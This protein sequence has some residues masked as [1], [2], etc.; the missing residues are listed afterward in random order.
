MIAEQLEHSL[1]ESWY[2]EGN[3][4]AGHIRALDIRR[5]RLQTRAQSFKR[6]TCFALVARNYDGRRQLGERLLSSR[7]NDKRR[8]DCPKQSDDTLQHR[9]GTKGQERL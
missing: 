4:T 8:D 6:A 2:E 5:Q 1:N 9:L 7:N 3:V